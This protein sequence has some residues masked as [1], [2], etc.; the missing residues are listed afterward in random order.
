M[1]LNTGTTQGQLRSY[2]ERQERLNDEAK[3]T[4]DD[5]KELKAEITG[6]GYCA[7]TIAAIVKR[8]A[9]D[10]GKLAEADAIMAL[11][12]EVMIG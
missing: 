1:N 11:Y 8:R 6:N 2:V 12:T 9:E 5:I 7:K 10:V 4:R 3:K